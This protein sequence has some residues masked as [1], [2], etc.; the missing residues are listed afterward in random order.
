MIK[1][2][3]VIGLEKSESTFFTDKSELLRINLQ[4]FADTADSGAEDEPEHDGEDGTDEGADGGQ[5]DENPASLE[6]LFEKFPHLKEQY[7]KDKKEAV[8][9]AVQKRFKDKQQPKKQD[10][11]SKQE[12]AE[13]NDELQTLKEQ[14]DQQNQLIQQAQEKANRASIKEYAMGNG[15][16]PQLSAALIPASK[17]EL[18]E[19]GDPANLDELFEEISQK[20]PQYFGV[21]DE[22]GA[23]KA[24]TPAKKTSYIPGSTIK[25]SNPAPKVDRYERGK[26]RAIAR[27]KREDK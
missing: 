7:D 5:D 12:E 22:D 8:K 26:Q 6:E 14:I 24:A 16:D 3:D 15:F 23:A 21:Q 4:F 19:D 25:K 11:S 18:D 17:V 9:K 10:K 2:N 20:F 1:S 27:H 13:D